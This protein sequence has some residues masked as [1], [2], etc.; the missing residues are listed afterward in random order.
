LIDIN[1]IAGCGNAEFA[2]RDPG[3]AERRATKKANEKVE[4]Q[5]SRPQETEAEQRGG[6]AAMALSRR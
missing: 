5:E 1:A 2:E 3:F 6:L 4:L